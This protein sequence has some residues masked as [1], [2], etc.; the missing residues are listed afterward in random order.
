MRMSNRYRAIF[1]HVPKTGGNSINTAIDALPD[2]EVIDHYG[3]MP[4]KHIWAARLK[5]L[6]GE[7]AWNS[8]F[9]FAV[10][11]NPWDQMVSC[12]HWWLQKADQW[13]ANHPAI[14]VIR[15]A[16]SFDGFMQ[17]P[18]GRSMIN[19]FEGSSYDWIC[20]EDGRIILDHVARF[21]NLPDEWREI[22]RRIG[23]PHVPLP[24]VNATTRLP[25]RDY[26]TPETREIVAQ[27]FRRTIDAFGYVF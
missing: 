1:I 21:E 23:A 4:S 25:Y 2:G 16:G 19:Q 14:A 3:P 27:R 18:Y 11:R 24:H 22:C 26:Y 7:A 9:T 17:L 13:P 15:E 6:V 12:Y 20:D 10:V 8:H 5:A